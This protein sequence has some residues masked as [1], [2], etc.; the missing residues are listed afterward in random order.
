MRLPSAFGSR[1]DDFP[2]HRK[3]TATIEDADCQDRKAVGER[4]G[5]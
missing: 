3:R 2:R 5:I 1:R 4:G